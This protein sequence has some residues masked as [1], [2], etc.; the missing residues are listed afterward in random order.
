MNTAGVIN[1]VAG[2]TSGSSDYAAHQVV[3][4][5]NDS[6]ASNLAGS[7]YFTD[8]DGT[9]GTG[10]EKV[11]LSINSANVS[12]LKALAGAE[13]L[14][15]TD[16][17][18][19]AIYS[20][21]VSGKTNTATKS[22]HVTVSPNIIATRL[23]V[24][25][26][27]DST[28]GGDGLGALVSPDTKDEV[29]RYQKTY[30]DESAK[31][32][33]S[34]IPAVTVKTPAGYSAG[35]VKFD[36]WYRDNHLVGSGTDGTEILTNQNGEASSVVGTTAYTY[37]ARFI[38]DVNGDNIDDRKQGLVSFMPDQTA[39]AR[40]TL[41]YSGID[42]TLS[43]GTWS[44]AVGFSGAGLG[45]ISVRPKSADYRF[46]GWLIG[47]S[48]I[49]QGANGFAAGEQRYPNSTAKANTVKTPL[50][51]KGTW[52][53]GVSFAFDTAYTK[54]G[55]VTTLGNVTSQK[56]NASP[57][58]SYLADDITGGQTIR[59][60]GEFTHVQRTRRL[61]Y[62]RFPFAQFYPS[63]LL[64]G[65]GVS[66]RYRQQR[67]QF[68]SHIR[69]FGDDRIY[70][71][72]QI[73]AAARLKARRDASREQCEQNK[74]SAASFF[75]FFLARFAR[76]RQGLGVVGCGSFSDISVAV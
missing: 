4:I 61:S 14:T 43:G 68:F 22:V 38:I 30:G 54:A 25:D 21:A 52:D 37:V 24:I 46:A 1:D 50:A 58:V 63:A 41:V 51:Y 35:Q 32:L 39:K 71:W 19:G 17:T 27:A 62:H 16:I 55:P 73:D 74:K 9:P 76:C 6:G 15:E 72:T 48:Y 64:R 29:S 13:E 59:G 47:N 57:Y 45:A 53:F 36:G 5:D 69:Y 10:S 18:I 23:Y 8:T 75:L 26:G 49:A 34:Q 20:S 42:R 66:L 7:P 67:R 12:K 28:N 40:G 44:P 11:Q 3:G 31:V 70:V 2:Y 33:A 65:H 56:P 60:E